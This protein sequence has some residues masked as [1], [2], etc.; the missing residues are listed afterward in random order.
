[1]LRLISGVSADSFPMFKC[2]CIM[3]NFYSFELPRL[4]MFFHTHHHAFKMLYF[5]FALWLCVLW[6]LILFFKTKAPSRKVLFWE[7]HA[8]SPP[9]VGSAH[10]GNQAPMFGRPDVEDRHVWGLVGGGAQ[11]ANHCMHVVFVSISNMAMITMQEHVLW[12]C[13]SPNLH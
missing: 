7:A 3:L 6:L 4:L 12:S 2:M 1:M 13:A 9:L 5:I 10:Q 11:L 8:W